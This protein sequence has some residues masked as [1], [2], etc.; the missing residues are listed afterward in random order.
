MNLLIPL[1]F[2]GIV[3]YN[4]TK[5]KTSLKDIGKLSNAQQKDITNKSKMLEYFKNKSSIVFEISSDIVVRNYINDNKG[6]FY[7]KYNNKLIEIT[8][9]N[10]IYEVARIVFAEGFSSNT[11]LKE[12][13]AI[14]ETVRNRKNSEFYKKYA[15]SYKSIIQQPNQ[16]LGINL[17]KYKKPFQLISNN[18][19]LWKGFI[20][21]IEATIYAI[22]IETNF[23]K[24]SLGFNQSKKIPPFNNAEAVNIGIDTIHTFWRKI[25]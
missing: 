12:Y 9:N 17:D 7:F 1:L 3:I 18:F 20:Y 5:A 24:N 11:H 16:F 25:I 4:S 23:S 8:E 22:Y 13:T 10:D 6:K 14:A 2:S 19:D 15:S 21:S